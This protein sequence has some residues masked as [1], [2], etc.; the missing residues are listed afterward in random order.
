ME[1]DELELRPQRLGSLGMLILFAGFFLVSV[2]RLGEEWWAWPGLL[3]FAA[4]GAFLA[5]RLLPGRAYLR[6]S[7]EGLTIAEP[8]LGTLRARWSD[9][10]EFRVVKTK[11]LG[12]TVHRSVAFEWED[13]DPPR[14]WWRRPL[15][16]TRSVPDNYGLAAEE[17]AALLNRW[18]ERYA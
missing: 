14:Q 11:Q 5:M 17:L 2:D 9:V 12:L 7:P 1:Q 13:P 8:F 16:K 6:L 10:S 18:R 15:G 4:V 3:V